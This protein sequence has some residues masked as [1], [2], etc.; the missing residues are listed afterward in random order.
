MTNT[1]TGLLAAVATLA[2]LAGCAGGSE[3][4]GV[5][6]SSLNP[7]GRDVKTMEARLVD[8]ATIA[9][10]DNT[11][12]AASLG[13]VGPRTFY[14]SGTTPDPGE[15]YWLAEK[16]K[17]PVNIAARVIHDRQISQYL[18]DMVRRLTAKLPSTAPRARVHVYGSPSYE[19]QAF[20]TGDIFISINVLAQAQSEDEIAALVGHELGHVML[21]HHDKDALFNKQRELTEKA[22]VGVATVGYLAAA[23]KSGTLF[24]GG[25]IP[26][27]MQ[28]SVEQDNAA[29]MG[30][31]MLADFVGN[32]IVGAAWNRDQELDADLFGLDLMA[33]AGYNP[34]EFEYGINRLAESREERATRLA[35]LEALAA[36][37]SETLDSTVSN[38]MSQGNF[39]AGVQAIV[40]E[41]VGLGIQAVVAAFGDAR[42]YVADN[43]T[44][45]DVRYD[46]GFDYIERFYEDDPLPEP[47]TTEW[48]SRKI[49]LRIEALNSAYVDVSKAM[50]SIAEERFQES[51]DLVRGAYAK[52]PIGQDPFPR[53]VEAIALRGLNDYSGALSAL[54]SVSPTYPMSIEGYVMFAELEANYGS[55]ANAIAVLDRAQ[56]FYGADVVQDARI[57][58]LAKLQRTDEARKAY[59]DCANLS[60]ETLSRCKT[61]A[62]NAGL[63]EPPKSSGG[64]ESLFS[65]LSGE[66]PASA[67]PASA[68][69]E[70][71]KPSL[72]GSILRGD[73]EAA[74][75]TPAV[76]ASSTTPGQAG[77]PFDG[78]GKTLGGLGGALF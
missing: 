6:P 58:T 49:A 75:Q 16:K 62:Q 64:F 60:A 36:R 65:G 13:N 3:V 25:T 26:A 55:G 29:L 11:S 4:S 66:S 2:L 44:D 15:N 40:T 73:T 77:S 38:A 39:N 70:P 27:A 51:L 22:V 20:P 61:A 78:L 32:D 45:P 57:I 63:I 35:N 30:A 54:R 10:G 53:L 37:R 59:E 31:K 69:S 23:G 74:G 19:A 24:N 12:V 1:R 17:A 9:V 48:K 21:A 33:D 46:Q 7:I 72:I 52:A 71:S 14:F 34:T 28:Q 56:R 42:A 47:K 5:I 68:S 41:G 67:T 8:T 76:P 50:G 18:N 43:Y